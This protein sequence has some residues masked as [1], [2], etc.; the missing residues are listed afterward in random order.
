MTT[1]DLSSQM[2]QF[3]VDGKALLEAAAV[4]AAA[5]QSA[6]AQAV[7]VAVSPPVRKTRINKVW[8]VEEVEALQT[9]LG[10]YEGQRLSQVAW[11]Q[12]RD[13]VG[14][15]RSVSSVAQKAGRFQRDKELR[16]KQQPAHGGVKVCPIK[17]RTGA[18]KRKASPGAERSL[19]WKAP[20]KMLASDARN[21]AA[22]AAAADVAAAAAAATAAAA[23]VAPAEID[24]DVVEILGI[25][26]GV[27]EETGFEFQVKWDG[28]EIT[29]EPSIMLEKC[30]EKVRKFLVEA[31]WPLKIN[32]TV[33][34]IKVEKGTSS[35]PA[36]VC[37]M[38]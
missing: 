23:A 13:I 25:R 17:K 3:L 16:D 14:T 9:A 29:W 30:R 19:A 38:F 37:C 22:A 31:V 12:V 28:G 18:L 15:G 24:Y 10:A 32:I 6:P 2:A 20:R 21:A 26:N 5:I 11:G 1:P 34:R 35:N 27:A 33:P 4:A 36:P 7:A 8:S